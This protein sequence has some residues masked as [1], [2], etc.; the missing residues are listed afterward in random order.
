[1]HTFTQIHSYYKK[2]IWDPTMTQWGKEVLNLN[3]RYLQKKRGWSLSKERLL[4]NANSSENSHHVV[5]EQCESA[6]VGRN[7]TG[8]PHGGLW[9]AGWAL[10][11]PASETK[12]RADGNSQGHSDTAR[13]S[14]LHT[15]I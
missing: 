11:I 4:G 12:M 1:M 8:D 5:H 13:G 6:A 2:L 14:I 10:D 7:I 15:T 3:S 9:G